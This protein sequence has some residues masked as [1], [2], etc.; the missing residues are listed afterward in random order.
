M[1]FPLA[2]IWSLSRSQRTPKMSCIGN[3]IK[4]LWLRSANLYFAQRISIWRTEFPE[5]IFLLHE[6]WTK[7]INIC[8]VIKQ[9]QSEVSQIH[10]FIFLTNLCTIFTATFCRKP[11]WNWWIGSKDMSSW[12]MLK[13]IGNKQNFLLC[14]A[15][16]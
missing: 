14:L 8:G 2:Q 3:C 4:K 13:T 6:C 10:F 12:R 16:S 7:Q 11:H 15:L 9:N 5:S 1:D